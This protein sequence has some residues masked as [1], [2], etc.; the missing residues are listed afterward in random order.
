MGTYVRIG[1]FDAA[2]QL[3]TRLCG[4]AF[5]DVGCCGDSTFHDGDLVQKSTCVMIRVEQVVCAGT[6]RRVQP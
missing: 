1:R 2:F 5:S 6:Y 3:L 4:F